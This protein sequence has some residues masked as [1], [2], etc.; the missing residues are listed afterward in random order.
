MS[1]VVSKSLLAKVRAPTRQTVPRNRLPVQC[2]ASSPKRKPSP[3]EVGGTLSG[4]K[5]AG[6]SAGAKA[7][8]EVTGKKTEEITSVSKFEDSRWV[9]G[10][11]DFNQFKGS[12]GETDW[13]AVI[14][15]EVRRRKILEDTPEAINDEP[16][17]FDLSMIPFKVW[18]TRFHLPVAEQVN[19]RAAMIGFFA[20]Y[21]LD[22]VFHVGIADAVGSPLGK[23]FMLAT[24]IG[25]AF[26]RRTEDLE[27]LQGLAD[28][29]TFYDR[30]WQATWDGVE[31]PSDKE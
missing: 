15:A 24:F 30:Q 9:Q 17:V 16:V 6:K 27:S 29:A 19:G 12:D 3:L 31:R 8:A 22:A 14:D 1:S 10:C 28:E 2:T 25:C 26:I 23:L 5:A 13:N 18:V 20:A 4:E 11:W 21:F 7:I